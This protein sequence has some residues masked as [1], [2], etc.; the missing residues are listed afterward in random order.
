[1]LEISEKKVV[2]SMKKKLQI[3]A[4]S[5]PEWYIFPFEINAGA[6]SNTETGYKPLNSK[7]TDYGSYELIF[8]GDSP[9]IVIWKGSTKIYQKNKG[10]K[11][12]DTG[13]V[14][15]QDQFYTKQYNL[16]TA[17]KWKAN[18]LEDVSEVN[19]NSLNSNAV[20][21]T[22]QI[23]RTYKLISLEEQLVKTNDFLQ[24][25]V[26]LNNEDTNLASDGTQDRQLLYLSN[27]TN[28]YDEETGEFVCQIITLSSVNDRASA[29]GLTVQSFIQYASPGSG[30]AFPQFKDRK[31]QF[32]REL[33]RNIGVKFVHRQFYGLEALSSI[34]YFGRPII[35]GEKPNQVEAEKEIFEQKVYASRRLF[36]GG[37]NDFSTTKIKNNG[38]LYPGLN[39]P[40]QTNSHPETTFY[41]IM[42]AKPTGF[43]NYKDWQEFLSAKQFNILAEKSFKGIVSFDAKKA[44][45]S[46][47]TSIADAKFFWD[48]EWNIN[49][50]TGTYNVE[51]SSNFRY[52][53]IEKNAIMGT[54][55]V[56][57]SKIKQKWMSSILNFNSVVFSSLVQ[58]PYDS[59]QWLPFSF[60]TLPLI[61]KMLNDIGLGIPV[62]WIMTQNSQQYKKMSYFNAFMSTFYASALDNI[63]SKPGLIP[64]N[65]FS[66]QSENEI[67]QMLGTKVSTTALLMKLTDRISVFPWDAETGARLTEKEQISTID[68]SQ[69][70]DD[71]V[72]IMDEETEFLD[73]KSPFTKEDSK[74]Q[75]NPTINGIAEGEEYAYIIDYFYTQSLAQGE[76]RHTFYAD[77]P[78]TYKGDYN[79]ISIAQYKI[80]NQ[81][82]FTNN[83]FNWTTQYKLN[84]DEYN[85]NEE[86]SFDYPNSIL[87]PDPMNIV[88]K[89][90]IIPENNLVEK[91]FSLYKIF[92]DNNSP[93]PKHII[94]Y[95]NDWLDNVAKNI[96]PLEIDLNLESILDSNLLINDFNDLKRF[97]K[98]IT[99]YTEWDYSTIEETTLI[100]QSKMETSETF[101]NKKQEYVF[102]SDLNDLIYYKDSKEL[103]L[104]DENFE[105]KQGHRDSIVGI[106][107]HIFYGVGTIS[108]NV[109]DSKNLYSLVQATIKGEKL[110]FSDNIDSY[111]K[112]LESN[113]YLGF[114]SL[115]DNDLN[116]KIQLFPLNL[117]ANT[118]MRYYQPDKV[119]SYDNNE[120]KVRYVN[121]YKIKISKIVLN[122]K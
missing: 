28:K 57:Y 100:N 44:I 114:Q 12:T 52:K 32:N 49:N 115:S 2:S 25:F 61:G 88:K 27:V 22:L 33:M 122:P 1:M 40:I 92:K 11:N 65:L 42:D 108:K 85:E 74:L 70:K 121:K 68:L 82:A 47:G 15:N 14:T 3:I 9:V 23:G 39:D 101:N 71:K 48:S 7:V 99:V 104:S 72:Y 80:K 51:M 29:N 13:K 109:N 73:I 112:S 6:I 63:F 17:Q 19:F 37:N 84:H 97:Y 96:I 62:G 113:L 31:L 103:V 110:T 18:L 105:I 16:E 111:S 107:Y 81:S 8:T 75:W 26:V 41:N 4:E 87:P 95:N 116:F 34:A 36:I 56:D 98:S 5:A 55:T 91:E 50:L 83:L 20:F 10:E 64:L 69:K 54:A 59:N 45:E 106:V 66:S 30:Y 43:T 76:E 38:G 118:Y 89:I 67:G 117:Y 21:N 46:N 93:L 60:S 35:Q 102:E 79:E 94:Y 53:D 120:W 78:F 119:G 24:F 86:T 90:E 77:N 58:M